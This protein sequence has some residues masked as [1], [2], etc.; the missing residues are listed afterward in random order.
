[1]EPCGLVLAC[2]GLKSKATLGPALEMGGR[3]L[4]PVVGH[5]T[6]GCL[7]RIDQAPANHLVL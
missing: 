3:R 7:A 2:Q 4:H 6:G 1:M 5:A